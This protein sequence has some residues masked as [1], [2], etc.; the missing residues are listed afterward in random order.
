MRGAVCEKA[1][2]SRVSRW[3][4]PDGGFGLC[5]FGFVFDLCVYVS[6][7]YGRELYFHCNWVRCLWHVGTVYALAHPL[8]E[9]STLYSVHSCTYS[10]ISYLVQQ[11]RRAVPWTCAGFAPGHVRCEQPE[12]REKAR[13][14]GPPRSRRRGGRRSRTWHEQCSVVRAVTLAPA[15]SMKSCHTTYKR[16]AQFCLSV[17]GQCTALHRPQPKLAAT[18]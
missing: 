11:A 17:A 5:A 9:Y 3:G 12:K 18:W 10:C 14:P 13:S 1:V 2:A 8:T 7:C 4:M 16:P 6:A 15:R